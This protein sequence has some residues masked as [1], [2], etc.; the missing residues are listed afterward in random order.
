PEP[1]VRRDLV[2]ARS[3][4]VELPGDRPDPPDERRLDVHVDVLEARVP[5]D[6]AGL[7]VAR[8]PFE[9][10]DQH[11]DFLVGQDPGPPQP[12]DV[13]DRAAQVVECQLRI[14]LDGA[15]E[16]RDPRVVLLAEPA[17]PEPHRSSSRRAWA[18]YVARRFNPSDPRAAPGR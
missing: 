11:R 12:P 9:P 8:Q 3:A 2:V 18:W 5:H 14:D 1:E 7:D 6:R 17:T 13:G 10:L 4:G 16:I 15:R